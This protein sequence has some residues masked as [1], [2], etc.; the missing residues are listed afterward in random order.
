M[1]IREARKA[2]ATLR[3]ELA[4][5]DE[6]YYRRAAPEI[7]DAEYDA[8]AR[9]LADIEAA[10]PALVAAG[11]PTGRVGDDSDARF[12]SLP[13][14]RPMIS[15]QN[16]YDL[17]EVAAFDERVRKETGRAGVRYTVEPKIDG[18]ALALRYQDGELSVALTR[19]DGKSGDV[20]TAN[21]LTIAGVPTRLPPRWRDRLPGRPRSIEVRGEAY[22][23]LPR[24]R[25]LNR[26][27]EEAGQPLLANPRN[28]TAG[29]LKTLDAAAVA[30]RGLSLFCYQIIGLDG[31]ETG[32]ATHHDEMAA[33]RELGLPVH[34]FLRL[35]AGAAQIAAYLAELE[36][37]RD[38]LDHVIDGA[39]IKVDELALH[40]SLGATAKAPRWG[41]A[42]KYAAQE[43]TTRVRDVVLQV[44]RTGVI[45]PVAELEPVLLGGTTVQRATLH[46]W[47]E[48]ARKDLR[49][50]DTVVVAKGGEIIPK[51]VRVLLEAR[52][53]GARSVPPPDRCPVCATPAVRP[54]G[55]VAVRC[56]NPLCPAQVARRLRHFAGRDAADIEG[57]GERGVAQLL[58]S[59]LVRDLPDL[60][61]LDAGAVAALPGW[62]EKSAAGLVQGIARASQRP[63]AAKLFALGIPEVGVTTAAALA[64]AYPGI[65]ALRAADPA[66]MIALY[67]VGEEMT[68]K[69][70]A[71][72]AR[73]DVGRLLDELATLGFLLPV[74]AATAAVTPAETWFRDRT[75]VLTG[76]L[77]TRPRS[78]A[79]ALLLR[80]GAK[81]AADVSRKTDAVIAGT[82]PGSKLD[83]ARELGVEVLDEAAWLQRLRREGV[84]DGA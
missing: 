44:G 30:A 84:D 19:G 21:A 70:T 46:N 63:W 58:E 50:G 78:E 9:R 7:E 75:F 41:L 27:R 62:A 74:E 8:L 71:F 67:G 12:P 66:G 16:S 49:V 60:F 61:R 37:R 2:A 28:A 18:V 40:P 72:L 57:L 24:F 73:D 20:V 32:L 10:F 79:K 80:L 15:L 38:G 48:I 3:A 4:R 13:H 6:L 31:D 11:S 1:D 51:V 81:V 33:L 76:T 22:L 52:P 54:E 69:I 26:Q 17:A 35:A 36:G 29:T 23:S 59:G 56:P 25:E 68:R 34:D 64:A 47:D 83:R 43:A 53:A 82:D 14:S 65:A 45:T 39:V 42:F 77:S 5:H 55:E